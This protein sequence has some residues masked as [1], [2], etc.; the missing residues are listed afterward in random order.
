[1]GK[2]VAIGGG[3]LRAGETRAIDTRIVELTGKAAPTALFIP[4]ASGDAADYYELSFRPQY[5]EA[6]GCPTDVLFLLN[7]RPSPGEIAAKIEAADL[8]YVGG[9]NTLRMMKLWRRLGV[10]ALLRRA[11]ERG[12]VL[13]GVSAGAIC[14]FAG[15]HSDSR[16]FAAKEGAAWNYIRVRGLGLV[17]GLYCPHVD[18]ENR[19][20]KFQQF[21]RRFSEVGIGCDDCCALEIVDDTCRVIT[22]RAGA[23][24][25]RIYRQR[26]QVTTEVLESGSEHPAA[27]LFNR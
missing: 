20:P 23:K 15:G 1:M 6:L 2:I 3:E 26:D 16:A 21:M 11:Y 12:T 8:I 5:G 4:T 24:A 19:L 22:S 14:W 7:H 18:G 10:D 27:A 17:G 25:Y 9:G 13:S